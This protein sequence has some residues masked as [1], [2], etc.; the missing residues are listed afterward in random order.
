MAQER[1]DRRRRNSRTHTIL[2]EQDMNDRKSDL[3]RRHVLLASTTLAAVSALGA[4]AS[5]EHAHA[6][7]AS[8]SAATQPKA[9][10]EAT[11]AANRALQQYLNFND[12][13]DFADA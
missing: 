7:Q 6:Q 3:T 13:Q 1:D 8:G 10:S 9:A 4:A 11:R 2:Q 12:R 5:I